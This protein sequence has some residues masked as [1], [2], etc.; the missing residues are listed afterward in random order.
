M[1]IKRGV[2]KQTEEGK[3]KYYNP[4]VDSEENLEA[5]D[6]LLA[7]TPKWVDEVL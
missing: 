1:Q 4:S 7:F 3:T 6:V 2:K 5:I